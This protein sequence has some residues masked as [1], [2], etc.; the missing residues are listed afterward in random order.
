[1]A[2][3]IKLFDINNINQLIW[4]DIYDHQYAKRFLLPMITD[5][6]F[7][8]I[9]NIKTDLRVLTLNNL[10]LPVTINNMEYEN[11]Y[12]CSLYTHYIS[13]A[14]EE[15]KELKNPALEKL[16]TFMLNSLGLVLKAGNI[17]K[18]VYIN[19]WMLSTNLYP[20]ISTDEIQE[21]TAYFKKN[22]LII[23]LFF[24]Q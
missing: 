21:I 24:D 18:T 8:Y 11:S 15:L 9:K 12:V 16:L 19:N 10:V 22:F 23:P 7:K 13:Y 14:I 4:S 17:N 3:S 6:V 5:G 20:E 1:M 2:Q